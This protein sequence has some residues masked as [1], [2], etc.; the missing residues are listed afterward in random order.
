MS[1]KLWLPNADNIAQIHAELTALFAREDDP[2]SPEGIKDMGLLESAA[3]RPYTGL[4]SQRK[5]KD[6]WSQLAA[7]FH[8]VA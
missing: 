7:L 3:Q 1:G 4:G 6:L 8:S 2:I 5:Y